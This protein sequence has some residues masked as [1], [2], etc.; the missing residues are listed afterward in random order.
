[1]KYVN[2][3]GHGLHSFHTEKSVTYERNTDFSQALT[4]S[5]WWSYFSLLVVSEEYTFK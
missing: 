4:P 2:V 5:E 1:M 3:S